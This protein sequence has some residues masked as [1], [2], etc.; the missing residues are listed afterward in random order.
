[1]DSRRA[2]WVWASGIFAYLVAITQRTSFGVA[3]LQATERFDATAAALSTFTVVQL[4]VYAGLQ[5]PVGLMVDKYGPRVMVAGGALL[6][7]AGQTALA[8]ASSVPEG[9]V[10]RV[11][12]GAGD[13]MT[14]VSVLRLLPSWFSAKRIPLLTQLTG[15]LGQIGQLISVIPFVAILNLAGWTPAFLSVAALSA[16]AFVLALAV[17]RNE[18]AQHQK[19]LPPTLRQ[20]GSSLAEAWREPGTRLGLWTHFTVQFPANVFMLM[21]GYPFLVSAQ[22]L[23]PAVASVLMTVAVLTSFVAGPLLGGWVGRHPLRRSTMVLLIIGVMS[24]AWL[25]VLLYP[26]PAPFWLLLLLVMAVS[27]GGPGSMIGFDFART[28]N[29]LSRAGT[30]TGIVN[31]GGFISALL[32]MF[33][34]GVVLDTLLASGF[35]QGELYALDSFKLAFSLQFVFLI[36]GTLAILAVRKRVRTRMSHGGVIVP[37]LRDALARD[38]RRRRERIRE[39][40]E[41]G[42]SRRG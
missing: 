31:V 24:T 22:G 23:A 7:L 36:G 37:P 6:M 15:Q 34:M 25:A 21:W 17:V 12:V 29:P 40:R 39:R 27:I 5:I 3:G 4:V 33:G 19:P 32:V 16:V 8:F 10:G 18:P 38:R 11:L 9:L 1:M 41:N 20:T 14:F 26:G 42:G 30:A 28:F 35:S 13:A 2:W